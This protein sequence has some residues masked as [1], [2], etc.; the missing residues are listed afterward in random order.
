ML[1]K[2]KNRLRALSSSSFL[3]NIGKMMTGTGF[4]HLLGVLIIPVLTRLY[5]PDEIGLY[6]SYLSMFTILYSV[7]SLRFEYATLIP[8]PSARP[9]MLRPWQRF[10]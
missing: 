8:A 5:T 4:A 9:I 2:L 7:A 3:R 1:D 10:W 6:A